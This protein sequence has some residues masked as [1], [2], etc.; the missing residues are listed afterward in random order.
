M[1]TFDMHADIGT[2][3]YR[4]TLKG[5]SD[6]L[7]T[8]H[9]PNLNEGD[10]KGVF[11]ACWFEGHEDLKTMQDM[12][13]NCNDLLSR[14]DSIRLVKNRDDLF[15]D[16]KILAL[17]SV[18]GMCG[19]KDNVEENIGWLYQNNVRVASLVW[20]EANA[21][22]SGW[23]Q[24]PM[25]GLSDLG[26]KAVKK[27]NELNMIIDVSHINEKGFWDVVSAS[28]RPVIAT[29]S[30]AR[31][32]CNHERNLTDQQIKAIV[33]LGGLIGLNACG[34]FVDEDK[35]EQ[36]ALKLAMHGRYI[37]D[38]VGV[39]YLACGFDY[40]NFLADMYSGDNMVRDLKDASYTPNLVKGLLEVGFNV[41]E[42]EDIMFNNVYNFLNEQFQ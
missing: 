24:D 30:N 17:I 10:I 22:A 7:K 42:V 37:A 11:T 16:D 8:V 20:N 31:K 28:N 21:L 4:R 1:K 39:K 32:L 14:E 40:M 15:V 36:S 35:S 33:S 2:D 26:F 13:L 41:K 19:I 34:D 9:L 5:E 25:Q 38:L 6:V 29:H 18:E 27:M 12:V 23:R 3:I